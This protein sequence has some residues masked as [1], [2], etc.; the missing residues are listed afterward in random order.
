[1]QRRSVGSDGASRLMRIPL[2]SE[3]T[4]GQCQMLARVVDELTADPGEELMREGDYGYE[5]LF[6]EEGTAEVRQ[7]VELINTVGPG[8]LVGELAV[9]D[10][11]GI[12]TGTVLVT[13]PL[14]AIVLTSHFMHE[15]RL[16]LPALGAAI[17][18]AAAEHLERDSLRRAGTGPD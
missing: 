17:E 11:G 7:G 1:M 13:S 8:A 18:R 6:I 4:A 5:V 15:V 12:R 10:A 9:L 14:R 3:L 2:L 16:R